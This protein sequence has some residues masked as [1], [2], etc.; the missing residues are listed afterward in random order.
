MGMAIK[1]VGGR[2]C[3]W[4]GFFVIRVGGGVDDFARVGGYLGGLG[5]GSAGGGM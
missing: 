1:V 4:P 2:L 3:R 5:G